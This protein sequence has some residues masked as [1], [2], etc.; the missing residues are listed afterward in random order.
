MSSLCL[1]GGLAV[2]AEKEFSLML[3]ASDNRD[4]SLMAQD[5]YMREVWSVERLTQEEEEQLIQRVYRG[6]CE[7]LKPLPNQWVLSLAR[8]ARDRLI[9]VYQS[10]VISLAKKFAFRFKSMGFMDLVQE[11]NLGLM[12]AI[13]EN[14]PNKGIPLRVLV[15]RCVRNALWRALRDRDRMVAVSCREEEA[16]QRMKM[17]EARLLRVLGREPE[18]SE[19]AAEMGVSEAIVQELHEIEQRQCTSLNAL[20]QEK[21]A[22]EV[23]D[24]VALYQSF[25]DEKTESQEMVSQA[26]EAVLTDREREVV[27]LRYGL[28]GQ[29][30]T[31]VD[32]GCQLGVAPSTVSMAESRAKK[33]LREVLA[34]VVLAEKEGVA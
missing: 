32:V 21:N 31:L 8:H 17:V 3:P 1:H 22:E 19:L 28:G 10:V 16:L 4:A 11:G 14:D 29:C 30:M 18:R 24:F 27:Q 20:L 2:N 6:R 33:R 25:C 15:F 23:F 13:D 9:E 7:R 12:A 34:P 5:Q 26:V